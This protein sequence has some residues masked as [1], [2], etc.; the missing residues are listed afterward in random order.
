M[1]KLARR[2]K[3]VYHYTSGSYQL[4]NERKKKE[5]ASIQVP[6]K[7]PYFVKKIKNAEPIYCHSTISKTKP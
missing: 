3:I 5:L 2:Q 4:Q 6:Q 1:G 7:Y